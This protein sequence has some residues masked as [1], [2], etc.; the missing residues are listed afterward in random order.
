MFFSSFLL[1]EK[2]TLLFLLLACIFAGC[3]QKKALQEVTPTQETA[4]TLTQAI[5]Q[6]VAEKT[7]KKAIASQMMI[8]TAFLG[9]RFAI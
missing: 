8:A 4:P 9:Q 2:V 5:T 7:Y 3:G 6:T 1:N